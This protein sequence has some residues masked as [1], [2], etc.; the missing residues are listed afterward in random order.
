M[1]RRK[2]TRVVGWH[3]DTLGH[4]SC[5]RPNGRLR[6]LKISKVELNDGS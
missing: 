2:L 1:E 6:V 4:T 5:T 3:G